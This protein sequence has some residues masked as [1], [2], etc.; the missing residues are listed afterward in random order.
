MILLK[1][2]SR[3]AIKNEEDRLRHELYS[4]LTRK[5]ESS[6]CLAFVVEQLKPAFETARD[7]LE[8][9]NSFGTLIQNAN[10]DLYADFELMLRNTDNHNVKGDDNQMNIVDVISDGMPLFETYFASTYV[11]DEN[12][13]HA[14][15]DD[16]ACAETNT[17]IPLNHV[18]EKS[19]VGDQVKVCWTFDRTYYSRFIFE[20]KKWR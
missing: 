13:P 12:N 17:N 7:A 8:Y 3:H 19:A 14:T 20:E 16:N 2:V 4:N 1:H 15:N 5:V 9:D 18:S 11:A 6:Q 10:D